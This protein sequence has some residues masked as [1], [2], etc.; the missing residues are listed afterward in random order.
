[1]FT[2]SKKEKRYAQGLG[3]LAD[4][5]ARHGDRDATQRGR[6]S[7]AGLRLRRRGLDRRLRVRFQASSHL[8]VRRRRLKR[9]I[10][11][12]GDGLFIFRANSANLNYI[13]LKNT[14][15]RSSAG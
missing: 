10:P 6:D 8:E 3:K 12:K 7:G 2:R 11:R 15:A 1:M 13:F 9:P 4:V 14:R 5:R